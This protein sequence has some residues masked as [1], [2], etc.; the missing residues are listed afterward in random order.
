MSRSDALAPTSRSNAVLV[1]GQAARLTARSSAIASR[2]T[3]PGCRSTSAASSC[4][5]VVAESTSGR[6][7]GVAIS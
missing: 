1:S 6:V 7:P 2:G 3:S 5:M 4:S